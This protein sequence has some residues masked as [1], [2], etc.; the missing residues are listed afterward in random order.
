[1]GCSVGGAGAWQE[2]A[3]VVRGRCAR[4]RGRRGV[5]PWAGRGA[6]TR[7]GWWGE[8]RARVGDPAPPR[9]RTSAP[10]VPEGDV[11]GR[12]G[13]AVPRPVTSRRPAVPRRRR[14]SPVPDRERLVR[15]AS[16]QARREPRLHRPGPCLPDERR[17]RFLAVRIGRPARHWQGFS[18]TRATRILH[19]DRG[20]SREFPAPRVVAESPTPFSRLPASPRASAPSGVGG[21][22]APRAAV[23][24]VLRAAVRT[25][26]VPVRRILARP[27]SP[28]RGR[29]VRPRGRPSRGCRPGPGTR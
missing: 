11:P 12:L 26:A 16:R 1:M 15:A 18:H 21:P 22:G 3:G 2:Y 10:S 7:L 29:P 27:S 8:V 6:R 13:A 20:A 25:A 5:R 24:Y 28:V 14:R 23:R 9:A 19:P 17:K 4:R